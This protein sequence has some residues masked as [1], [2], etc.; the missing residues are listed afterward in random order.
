MTFSRHLFSVTELHRIGAVS[1]PTPG[2]VVR[3][4][5]SGRSLASRSAPAV[6][7]S[8]VGCN[9][10]SKSNSSCRRQLTQGPI[11]NF[12]NSARAQKRSSTNLAH[13]IRLSLID[14]AEQRVG[15]KEL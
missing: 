14:G 10:S 1:G 9:Q 4:T 8:I 5:T 15:V 6:D 7:F 3:R 11:G 2:S 12:S 13:Y